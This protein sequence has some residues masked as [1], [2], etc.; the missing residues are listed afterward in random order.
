MIPRLRR[1]LAR[2]DRALSRMERARG[3]RREVRETC[4][5]AGAPSMAAEFIQRGVS[6]ATVRRALLSCARSR[7]C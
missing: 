6:P 5:I 2:V 3:M 1:I 4:E 7:P